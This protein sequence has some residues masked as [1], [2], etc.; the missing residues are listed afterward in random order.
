MKRYQK[1][2]RIFGSTSQA[3][4]R[5]SLSAEG[6][7]SLAKC[8]D[9]EVLQ[10]CWTNSSPLVLVGHCFQTA[11]FESPIVSLVSIDH[12]LRF[13][14]GS[15]LLEP[16]LASPLLEL[17]T[18]FF[19]AFY[20]LLTSFQRASRLQASFEFLSSS[21]RASCELLANFLGSLCKLSACSPLS[22]RYSAASPPSR[23]PLDFHLVLV[24]KPF[25]R[26]SVRTSANPMSVSNQNSKLIKNNQK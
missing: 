1:Q 2:F 17:S 6:L 11:S 21:F 20:R 7:R 19:Q 12:Q 18:S 10:H 5:C 26:S 9:F 13:S 3:L 22:L 25:A 4:W 24:R 23:N 14:T 15:S 8:S 16:Q